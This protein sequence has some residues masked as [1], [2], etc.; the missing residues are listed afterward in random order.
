[1]PLFA[2]TFVFNFDGHVDTYTIDIFTIKGDVGEQH[3]E[4]KDSQSP[5]V[6][7]TIVFLLVEN[8]WRHVICSPAKG[9]YFIEDFP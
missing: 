5:N 2:S 6:H 8:L 9:F 1:M 4:E 3:I 7:R